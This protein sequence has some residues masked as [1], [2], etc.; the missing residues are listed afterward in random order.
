MKHLIEFGEGRQHACV[1]GDGNEK[2]RA[3]FPKERQIRL[4]ENQ[5]CGHY[6]S[7]HPQHVTSGFM[8]KE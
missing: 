7:Q 6:S 8:V 1:D 4:A 5:Q 2:G 3:R